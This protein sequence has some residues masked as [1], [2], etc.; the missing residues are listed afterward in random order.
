MVHFYSSKGIALPGCQFSSLPTLKFYLR[1]KQTFQS[2]LRMQK[3]L[4]VHL[5]ASEIE[6]LII[7]FLQFCIYCKFL[8]PKFHFGIKKGCLLAKKNQI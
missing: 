4:S 1:S 6:S 7:S 8:Y 5:K 3:L 2:D